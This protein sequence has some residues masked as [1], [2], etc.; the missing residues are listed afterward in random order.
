MT[1]YVVFIIIGMVFTFYLIV[2]VI[3]GAIALNKMKKATSRDELTGIGIVTLLFCNLLGGIF[4]LCTKD[5][6]YT[7]NQ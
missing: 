5:E 1:F 3:V 6:D 2:P 7:E 4:L